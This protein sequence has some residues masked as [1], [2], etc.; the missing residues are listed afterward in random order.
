MKLLASLTQMQRGII[1]ITA[2][3]LILL[4][5][6]G[7]L[8]KTVHIIVFTAALGLIV[9]GVKLTNILDMLMTKKK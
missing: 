3:L 6:I 7:V 2:G 9:Y 4:D 1:F 8:S 5:S